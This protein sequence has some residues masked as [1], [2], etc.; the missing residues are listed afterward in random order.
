MSTLFT[1][2][3]IEQLPP[4][5]NDSPLREKEYSDTQVV[6]LKL[7]VNKAGRKFFYLRYLINRRK[8]GIKLGEFGVMSLIEARQKAIELK[9]QIQKGIDPQAEKQHLS[10]IPTFKAFV[11]DSY[12]PWAYANKI[13]ANSD[14]SKISLHLLPVFGNV[15]LDHIT[16]QALQRY[17]DGLKRTHTPAT[18]NRHLSL[19]SRLL[20]MAV[21]FGTIPKNPA[22]GIRKA[23]ENNE[24]QRFLSGD[25]IARFLQALAQ[26]DNRIAAAFLEFLL[27][28]GVRRSE[29]LHAQWEHVD[30]AKKV[31]FIPRAKNGKHRH[32]LLNAKALA[33]LECL[34][35]VN[36]YVF[37]GKVAGKP[38]NNPQ[39]CFTRT[40]Q[41]AGI[42]DFRLHDLRHTYASIAINNGASLYEVQHLLG[43]S[44]VKTT[45]RYAHLADDTLRRVSEEV[46]SA[47]G[48][49]TV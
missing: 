30:M 38:L 37:P 14:A 43:H 34:P 28:T 33:M 22:V 20:N 42:K 10:T 39:K 36:A 2:R 8:R 13:S 17:I 3:W 24:R 11:Q 23:Q 25:E 46:S 9:A 35:R 1:K 40:L 16:P 48:K 18:C 27:Y 29:A 19:L 26:D 47:I 4:N 7:L 5:D 12:L 49:V 44:Q 21:Q 15:R 31:W 41:R 32:V 45:T 6:G